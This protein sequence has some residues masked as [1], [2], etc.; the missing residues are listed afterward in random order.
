MAHA[1]QA[2][3]TSTRKK[4]PFLRALILTTLLIAGG[5]IVWVY[6]WATTPVVDVPKSPT[7]VQGVSSQ[8]VTY[9]MEFFTTLVPDYLV[10][11][12]HNT[13]TQAPLLGQYVLKHRQPKLSD[14]LAITVGVL[15]AG[16]LEEIA[17]LKVRRLDSAKYVMVP[18]AAA[19][20]EGAVT[21]YNEAECE[22]AVFWTDGGR[23][24]I[25]VTS[26]TAD[27]KSDLQ[28]ARDTVVSNWRW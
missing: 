3:P 27:R 28:V 11:K 17:D 20:P 9:A 8:N 7:T 1:A 13:K 5:L 18:N 21:I 12:T 16:G 24:A 14:Q 15:P 19:L 25:V 23:F 10:E 22:T 4:R 6:Q 2:H 26:G